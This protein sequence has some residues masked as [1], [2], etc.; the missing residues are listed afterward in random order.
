MRAWRGLAGGLLTVVL[1][2]CGIVP[3]PEQQA[4]RDAT[5]RVRAKAMRFGT[6]LWA[7]LRETDAAGAQ[8][9]I[10]QHQ[11]LL[12]PFDAAAG[13][14]EN[15]VLGASAAADGTVRLDLAFRDKAD[16]GGGWSAAQAVVMLCVRLTGTPGPGGEVR[17]VNLPCPAS[18]VDPGLVDEVVTLARE[19]P[20]PAPEPPRKPC[21]SG[22]SNDCAG[23]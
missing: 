6:S 19:G 22:G 21:H 15:G 1:A 7:G 16:A 18:V 12:G 17:L 5:D 14:W 2:G 4:R 9:V 20:P 8:R 11:E 13:P 23:G 10:Q 3:H